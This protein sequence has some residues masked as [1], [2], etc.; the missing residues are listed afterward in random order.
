MVVF[1]P[2]II[3][4]LINHDWDVMGQLSTIK[5]QKMN[6]YISLKLYI[7]HAICLYTSII[8]VCLLACMYVCIQWRAR[9][10]GEAG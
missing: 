5:V 1:Q 9:A 7:F 2:N 4:T 8:F 6:R 10:T 3:G